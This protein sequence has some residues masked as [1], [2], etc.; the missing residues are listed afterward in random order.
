MQLSCDNPRMNPRKIP[1]A[2][3]DPA[4]LDF[5]HHFVEEELRADAAPVQPVGPAPGP[6]VSPDL[7]IGAHTLAENHYYV[8]ITRSRPR[9]IIDRGSITVLVMEDDNTTRTILECLIEKDQGYKVRS[10]WDTASFVLAIQQRPT[11][12]LIILDLEFPGDVSG[13]NILAKVRAHP[14]ISKMPVIIFTMHSDPAHLQEGLALG[15]DAYLSKP[16]K[17]GALAEVIKAV[18]GG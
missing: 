11:P 18:L 10:A 5:T 17:A 2:P 9:R 15:A 12:D 13:F 3:A 4:D 1:A 8:N 16:A 7:L 6:I 14:L